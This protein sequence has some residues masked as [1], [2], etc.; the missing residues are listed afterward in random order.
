MKTAGQ[1]AI[2]DVRNEIYKRNMGLSLGFF[3]RQTTGG[4]MSRVLND[5]NLMQSGVGSVIT[6][7]FRDGLSAVSLLGVIFYRDWQLALISFI[8]I[9]VI[10]IPAQIIGKRIKRLVKQG[11]GMMGSIASVLQETFSGI[12]VIK[13]FGLEDREIDKFRQRNLDFYYFTRKSIKYES[14][15]TPLTELITS[16]GVAAVVWFGGAS[17][18][19]GRMTA[20]EFFSFVAAMVMMYNPIKKLNGDYNTMQRSIGASERVF[21]II[22][23]VPE[24]I[25]APDAQPLSAVRG[26]V[27][28][29]NVSFRYQ[30]EDKKYQLDCQQR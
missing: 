21:E 17:V 9:P 28:F 25:D 18:I 2:Q 19:S 10:L 24:I 16:F 13:A 12:K 7:V 20:A 1:L 6:G 4:M 26:D 27:E 3:Q 8:V 5:V 22:D 15:S 29:R 30:D 11:Q 14:L 23:A